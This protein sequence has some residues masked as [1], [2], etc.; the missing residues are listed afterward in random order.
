MA[1]VD[2]RLADA[3]HQAARRFREA[4]LPESLGAALDRLAE[5]VGQPCTVAVVG[6]VKAG[7]ST[8]VN[9]LLGEDLAKVGATETTATINYFLYGQ[10]DP[11]RPVRCYWRGGKISDESREFLDSLQGNDTATLRRAEGI[12]HLEYMLPVEYLRR[13][14]LIDTPGTAAAVDE[15]QDRTA[16]FM[17]LAGQLRQRHEQETETIAGEA[18]AVVYLVGQVA[19]T[20]DQDFLDEFQRATAGRSHVRNSVGVLAK[21]DLS[22]DVIA[23]RLQLAE[24]I[25][26]QLDH[27]LNTVVPVSAALQR[28]LDVLLS[29]GQD[30]V[31]DMREVLREIP[32]RRLSMLLDNEE[33][34]ADWESD[35][36]PVCVEARRGLVRDFP[37]RVFT[38]IAQLISDPST[39]LDGAL[40]QLREIAGFEPLKQ[41]LERR[42][43]DR[44]HLIRAYR[45]LNDAQKVMSAVRLRYLHELRAKDQGELAQARRFLEFVQYA[46]GDATVR[47]ELADFIQKTHG[48]GTGR[49]ERAS[50][51]TAESDRELSLILHRVELDH[52]DMDALERVAHLDGTDTVTEDEREELRCLFG[53]YGLD[54]ADRLPSEQAGIGYIGERQQAWSWAAEEAISEGRRAIA[55]QAVDRYGW[56]LREMT[57]KEDG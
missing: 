28:A 39:E 54:V 45:I 5:Q 25:G 8:F 21:I 24:K 12:D 57:S 27:S 31:S 51:A 23:R 49:F 33:L 37:W 48:V 10:A 47:A 22:P 2:T 43:F 38:T 34:F 7:K 52:G 36:C 41:V 32:A 16:E 55:R 35:D 26:E 50:A 15:H 44:G 53:L 42:F 13:I 17:A 29:D 14:T 1:S 3:L 46:P 18:D 56:I 11:A 4:R 19:R 30:A 6:R 20:T 40:R 9:A